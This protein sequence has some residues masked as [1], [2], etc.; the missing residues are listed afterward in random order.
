MERAVRK[1]RVERTRL[2]LPLKES[3]SIFLSE[4]IS[5]NGMIRSICMHIRK[6]GYSNVNRTPQSFRDTRIQ[7]QK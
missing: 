1:D 7:T 2:H 5:R 4:H 3:Q 6:N